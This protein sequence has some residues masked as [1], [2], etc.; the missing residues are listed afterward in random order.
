MTAKQQ[1]SK[2]A[3]GKQ[4][5]GGDPGKPDGGDAPDGVEE[6]EEEL[7]VQVRQRRVG[8]ADRW[9]HSPGVAFVCVH[10]SMHMCSRAWA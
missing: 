5:E 10:A 1:S 6:E 7:E 8:L 3:S 9:H 2:A 4:E